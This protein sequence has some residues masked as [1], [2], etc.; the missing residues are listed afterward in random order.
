MEKSLLEPSCFM[1]PGQDLVIAG[2]I[3][4]DGTSLIA[5]TKE[6]ELLKLYSKYFLRKVKQLKKYMVCEEFLESKKELKISAVTP[7]GQ[8]GI[9]AALWYMSGDYGTG[10]T[11]DLKA[12]PIK[13]ET[14]EICEVFDINPYRLKSGGSFLLATNH[15][16]DL[17]SKLEEQKIPAVIIG[18]VTKGIKR[19]ILNGDN[20]SFL[21]RP[22]E[23]ELIKIL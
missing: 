17:V 9:M 20:H 18:K 2:I 1:S 5:E 15:G 7:I 23:D 16:G 19:L 3:A 8:G 6:E 22:K 13:Q 14:V 10:I 11:I 4:L 21:D 12:I